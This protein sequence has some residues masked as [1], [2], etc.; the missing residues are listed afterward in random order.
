MGARKRVSPLRRVQSLLARTLCGLTRILPLPV[1]RAL[2]GALSRAALALIPRMRRIGMENLDVVFGDTLD[3][4]EKEALLREAAENLGL[5]AAEFSRIPLV[6]AKGEGSL[7]E[8]RGLEN[9]DRSRGGIFLSAHIGNWEWLAP[10][11]AAVGLK[12]LIVV[13]GFDD[14]VMDQAVDAIRR[15]P[16]VETVDKH[17]ALPALVTAVKEGRYAGILA[18]QNPRENGIPSV[19]FGRETWSTIGPAM[20]ARRAKC[21]VYPVSMTREPG[22]RYVLEFFPPVEMARDEDPLR[23]L[24]E[25]TQRCQNALEEM[26]LRRPGQWLWFHRR[27]RSRGRHELEWA[28]RWDRKSEHVRAVETGSPA[29]PKD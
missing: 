16:G 12:T 29:V 11:G 3:R 13:R 14:P 9:I 28:E 24:Q 5:V 23:E 6:T 7:F 1:A 19:F 18:D 10:A 8:V 21:P 4:G 25:N 15:V 17:S 27:W 2:G 20:L 22:G 26:I